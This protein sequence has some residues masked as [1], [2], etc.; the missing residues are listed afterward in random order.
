MK[1]MPQTIPKANQRHL[2]TC[3]NLL[4]L[5]NAHAP[6]HQSHYIEMNC[7]IEQDGF[8]STRNLLAMDFICSD[9]RSIANL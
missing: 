4:L 6:A 2:I 7:S 8:R 3:N 9:Q 1:F 5:L